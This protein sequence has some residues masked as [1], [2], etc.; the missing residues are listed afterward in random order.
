MHSSN[1]T[2]HYRKQL[3]Y[4]TRTK[5]D[6]TST[7]RIFNWNTSVTRPKQWTV[8]FPQRKPLPRSTANSSVTICNN[9]TK[10]R[11][12]LSLYNDYPTGFETQK[13]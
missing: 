6:C 13:S 2:E 10:E 1:H 11:R 7:K 8:A 3:Y 4:L 5:H 9:S 12:Q